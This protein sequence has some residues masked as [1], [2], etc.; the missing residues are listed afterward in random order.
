MH[1]ERHVGAH[2]RRRRRAR[3]VTMMKSRPFLLQTCFGMSPFWGYYYYYYYYY[4]AKAAQK[5]AFLPASCPLSKATEGFQGF[6][7]KSASFVAG[8]PS[9][10]PP[11]RNLSAQSEI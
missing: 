7:K 2:P 8:G 3:P 11:L 10:G 5:P 6:H 1:E 4:G 9:V